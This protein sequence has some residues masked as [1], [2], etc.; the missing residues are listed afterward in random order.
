M[1]SVNNVPVICG[2][3]Y[4]PTVPRLSGGRGESLSDYDLIKVL[5]LSGP[6]PKDSLDLLFYKQALKLKGTESYVGG[7]IRRLS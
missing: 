1:A 5:D 3:G 4:T 7:N 2:G 6:S